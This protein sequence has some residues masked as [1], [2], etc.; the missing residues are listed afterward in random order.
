M[1]TSEASGLLLAPVPVLHGASM[2]TLPQLLGCPGG[3]AREAD[4]RG[5]L[6]TARS[7]SAPMPTDPPSSPFAACP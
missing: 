1:S 2:S 4:Q 5:D 3:S 7:L 6:I